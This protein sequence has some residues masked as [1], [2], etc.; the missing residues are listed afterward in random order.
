MTTVRVK[1]GT[2]EFEV[3]C[4]E[5]GPVIEFMKTLQ[6]VTGVPI[7]NQKLTMRRRQV[8]SSDEW[9]K[10]DITPK[11]RFMLIGTSE[12]APVLSEIKTEYKETEYN[13]KE[14]EEEEK[15]LKEFC[16]GLPNLG[17]TCYLNSCLQ[18]FRLLP[19]FRSIYETCLISPE[20]D[21]YQ[22]V[23]NIINLFRNFPQGLNLVF[24]CLKKI[25]PILFNGY[26]EFGNPSQQDVTES[27]YYLSNLFKK[28]LGHNFSQ[29]FEICFEVHKNNINGEEIISDEID[30]HLSVNITEEVQQIEQGIQ[31]EEEFPP[32]QEGI[33]KITRKINQLPE[34]LTIQIL[35]FTYKKEEECTAKLV[36]R[37]NHP[38]ELD[39]LSWLTQELRE[40]VLL[41]RENDPTRQNYGRY[42]LKS[43]ITHR[44]RSANSGHYITH[45]RRDN[46][47]FRFD[48]LKVTEVNEES[49]EMLSGSG[50]WHCSVLLIYEA[51]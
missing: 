51:L 20:I 41:L 8:K 7:E 49:I 31:F 2:K 50:D 43:V 26:D 1:W 4:Q 23:Q 40:E 12:L 35:R 44:G 19:K 25:N 30:N 11:T 17:N 6:D 14:K 34:Y 45:V 15:S 37:V 36:R 38:F 18:T 21:Q 46:T 42:R 29:L 47:W 9:K 10:G 39:C 13:S 5:E 22:V 48:D 16:Q 32:N 28:V 27:W 3:K 33:Y 24:N